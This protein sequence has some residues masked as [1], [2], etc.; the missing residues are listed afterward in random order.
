MLND[1]DDNIHMFPV[2]AHP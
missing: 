1:D 2:A